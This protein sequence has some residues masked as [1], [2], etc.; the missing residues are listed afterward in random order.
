MA[1]IFKEIT[2]GVEQAGHSVSRATPR[3]APKAAPQGAPLRG[4]LAPAPRAPA[5]ST[6]APNLRSPAVTRQQPFS[7]AQHQ[8]QQRV[9][10]AQARLPKAPT[11]SIPRLANP[12]PAQTHV[13]LQLVHRSQSQAVG[14]NPTAARIRQ[15]QTELANDPRQKEFRETVAHYVR[16]AEGHLRSSQGSV[17]GRGA[18]G[19][20]DLLQSLVKG[21][22]QQSLGAIERGRAEALPG[23]E[24]EA[25]RKEEGEDF[26]VRLPGATIDPAKGLAT[27]ATTLAKLHVPI[28]GEVGKLVNEGIDLP[29]QTFLTS[30]IAGAAA[31]QAAMKG[32]T[33]P[34]AALGK[35]AL[36]QV[37]HPVQ[38]FKQ[39]PFSTILTLA[40]GEAAAEGLL[41][42]VLRAAPSDAVKAAL[43]TDRPDLKLYNEPSAP[44]R[45]A[46]KVDTATTAPSRA[47]V[48]APALDP[49][50]PAPREGLRVTG[51]KYDKLPSRMGAQKLYEKALT[52]LPEGMG[53]Q[54]DPFQAEGWRLK[55]ALVGGK[56][57]K[58]GRVDYTTTGGEQQR[59]LM[60]DSVVKKTSGDAPTFPEHGKEAVPL[61]FDNTIRLGPGTTRETIQADLQKRIA[62]LKHVQP[63]LQTADK[64]PNRLAIE[65]AEKLLAD[66]KFL[67]D[68]SEAMAHAAYLRS[69]V[70]P[71]MTGNRILRGGLEEQA[72]ARAPLFEYAQSH[73]GARHYTVAEHQAA[74]TNAGAA[75]NAAAEKIAAGA[76]GSVQEYRAAR[77]HRM[78]VSGRGPVED[79]VAHEDGVRE[80]AEAKKT[81]TQAQEDVRRA[82]NARSRLVGARGAPRP[83]HDTAV[84]GAGS[85]MAAADAKVMGAKEALS[86]AQ[87]EHTRLKEQ[88]TE[89]PR[90]QAGLRHAN[91]AY[92]SN[93]EIRAHM[94][95]NGV[96][97]PGF[98]SH[99]P[100]V[101]GRS[102]Y[103][104]QLRR[105]PAGENFVK[106]GESYRKGTADTS[107]DALAGH[108]AAEAGKVASHE[109]RGADLNEYLVGGHRTDT[110]AE[111]QR[112]IDNLEL[113]ADGNRLAKLGKLK[114]VDLGRQ[115]VLER[116][117]ALHA[118]PTKS[119]AKGTLDQLGIEAHTLSAAADHGK[120][121]ILPDDVL[122]R[123]D[124]HDKAA[125][126]TNDAKRVLQ[127]YNQGFRHVKFATSAKR[128]AGIVQEQAI[129]LG[130]EFN[131]PVTAALAN[132]T[133]KSFQAAVAHLAQTDPHGQLA[134]VFGPEGAQGRR[135][136][137][138]LAGRGGIVASMKEQDINRSWSEDSVKGRVAVR[139]MQSKP[140]K[141]W[142]T[143]RKGTE[144][145][146]TAVEHQTRSALIGK[147]LK[148]SGFVDSY[149]S[150]LKMQ[151][152]GM[153]LAVEH[154]LTANDAIAL[155]KMVDDM[156]GNW[157]HQTPLV[158]GAVSTVTPF[159]LWWLNSMR[160]LY[161]L[162]VTHPVKTGIL[163]ALYHATQ[164]QRNAE[165]QGYQASGVGT[166][167]H[168][169]YL[170]GTIPIKL[171]LIGEKLLDLSHYS[172]FGVG[173]PEAFST[174]AQQLFPAE[175]GTVAGALGVNPLTLKKLETS[176]GKELPAPAAGLNAL[177]ELIAGPTLGATQVQ[178]LTENGRK[179]YGTANLITDLLSK[180]GGPAQ[181]KPG[182]SAPLGDTLLKLIDPLKVYKGDGSL[183]ASTRGTGGS[184][185]GALGISP[186]E[187]R[188][189]KEALKSQGAGAK[190]APA[191]DAATMAEIKAALAAQK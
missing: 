135:L 90:I 145:A 26:R 16:A 111:A 191:Y 29:G 174:A 137:G 3:P 72:A 23:V 141:A 131:D 4:G 79:Q 25:Q 53:R 105:Y 132:R 170:Q 84:E 70:Q 76:P 56:F 107:Y 110:S 162:P 100:G 39:A 88:K 139:A 164:A 123:M 126:A 156:G 61:M 60:R 146:L 165:G 175:E 33:K 134:D 147:A 94:K 13:A 65:Q 32:N 133:G 178:E 75:Q 136:Q 10:Q 112:M 89:I 44:P 62:D 66:K 55:R 155:A 57:T 101:A 171:P 160:W 7:G 81:V 92:L 59:R 47:P 78:E 154:K 54:E 11:P 24:R 48:R 63:E 86:A 91:G 169:N 120:Y 30:Q 5:R 14:P 118:L 159:G 6:S 114:V 58:T 113:G 71:S 190:T 188:E 152:K 15:Y 28:G 99:K 168:P 128:S 103:I 21:V 97:E 73:M 93:E 102:S 142:L 116:E 95:A 153:R 82:E 150:A 158:K 181:T 124:S 45:T 8:A 106:T 138:F 144:A 36:H 163:A 183:S 40:G 177:S 43:S 34:I 180:I 121:G 80:R 83:A 49:N 27:V 117:D 176:T 51:R 108:L 140:F 68:P 77:L 184:S 50:A 187:K 67:A 129:R 69:H 46:P 122:K 149:R 127:A 96:D 12:T 17:V 35:Q 186:V 166:K 172:P 179:P 37:E 1:S 173:G 52:K 41:A 115:K 125:S 119:D 98:L 20:P 104:Q 74:E 189:I 85:R 130:A 151:E 2:K 157:N 64:E 18:S 22:E 19:A 109:V 9:E 87:A 161:R 38:S 185:H 182:P 143:Y 167:E 42:K 31:Y 148:D